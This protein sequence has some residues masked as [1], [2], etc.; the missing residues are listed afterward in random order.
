MLV[1]HYMYYKHLTSP[2]TANEKLKERAKAKHDGITQ[3]GGTHQL[4]SLLT[5]NG[6]RLVN[7]ACL[8]AQRF[9]I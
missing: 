8:A 4:V 2:H 6:E 5:I 3:C 7:T 9:N 1:K